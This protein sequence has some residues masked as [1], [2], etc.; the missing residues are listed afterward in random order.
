MAESS[1]KPHLLFLCHRIPFPPNKGDKIRSFHLL[2]ALAERYQVHLGCFVDDPDDHRYEND[3]AAYCSSSCFIPLS[4]KRGRLRSLSGLFNGQPLSLPYY[5]DGR[6]GRWVD[7][8]W[9]RH[10]ITRIVVF[11]SAMAQYVLDERFD[12]ARR[13]ID[14]VDVDS[15]KWYQYA[16]AKPPH[17][18][19]LFRR[20][21]RRLE[22]YD[23]AV[24]RAFEVSL[25]VSPEEAALFRT[26][27]GDERAQVEQMV[28]GVDTD[29]FSPDADR[30][31][32]FPPEHRAIVFTGAMDYWANVDAVS[33][34]CRRVLPTIRQR[35]ADVFFY[36]VGSRPAD[37]VLRL[38]GEGVVVTGAVEDVRPYLQHAAAAAAPM[39][40]ARGI[41]NKVLEAMSMGRPLVV[42]SKGLEGIG[43]TDGEELLVADTPDLFASKLT[44][45]LDGS[46]EGLGAR[47]RD[48]CCRAHGWEASLNRFMGFLEG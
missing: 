41:Q 45:L 23:K 28:N 34:F 39:Q 37:A 30:P 31:R 10:P 18:A 13:V 1:D 7:Q 27:L 38:A 47:A 29:Y 9:S 3:V 35:S 2:R 20:E 14:F 11:S 36:I 40:I 33:W 16:E 32:P 19:W 21:G 12:S 6:M 4:G 25:F 8:S 46:G 44:A 5:K 26:L 17:S 42:T 15:D 24:A 22:S 48:Y 43:A